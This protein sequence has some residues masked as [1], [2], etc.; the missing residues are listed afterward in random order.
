MLIYQGVT[1]HHKPK[2]TIEFSHCHISTERYLRGAHPV[3]NHAGIYR[4]FS[5]HSMR[6][7]YKWVHKYP[8]MEMMT[9]LT[10]IL[11]VALAFDH[12]N[13]P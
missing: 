7:F 9:Q 10:Q 4:L 2:L 12:G 6:I 1:I 8:L 5:S 11:T 13:L 3:G